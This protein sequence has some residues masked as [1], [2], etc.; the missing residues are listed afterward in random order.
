MHRMTLPTKYAKK[1]AK[2]HAEKRG[3][4]WGFTLIELLVVISIIA[5]LI[6][7]TI[8]ALSKSRESARRLKC[9]TNLK[10]L[11]AAVAQYINVEGQGRL[12]PLVRPDN[13]P[14]ATSTGDAND[15][16]IIEVLATHTDAAQPVRD[17][18]GVWTSFDPW[19]C[20]SDSQSTDATN[21]FRPQ[22]AINGMSYSYPPGEL[23]LAAEL[24]TVR[25]P[26]GGVS[27]VY[28][29]RAN[30]KGLA[31]LADGSSLRVE[32]LPVFLDAD[33]WHNPRWRE[34]VK[35]VDE[36]GNR[37]SNEAIAWDR[38]AVYLD[39]SADKAAG[40]PSTEDAGLL[41]EDIV[42]LGGGLGE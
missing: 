39:G 21:D 2:K 35:D 37:R 8:P 28:E 40:Q 1:H 30:A 26:Q 10:G 42:T 24:F 27:R 34:I 6:G 25:D 5:L 31:N 13:N 11:G 32:R 3:K 12:L 41:F 29:Q 17:A 36:N 22:W 9:L 14:P 16:S 23:M 4:P 19:R 38:N 15:P 33:N 18:S 20:P 7:I